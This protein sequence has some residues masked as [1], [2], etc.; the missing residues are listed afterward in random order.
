MPATKIE[1]DHREK[2]L[3]RIIDLWHGQK[4]LRVC[5]EAIPISLSHPRILHSNP[6]TYFVILSNILLGSRI[7]VGST[8]R[9]RSAPGLSC[10]MICDNTVS[11]SVLSC[12]RV[13]QIAREAAHHCPALA[14]QLWFRPPAH[15]IWTHPPTICCLY[16]RMPSVLCVR[17]LMCQQRC[18]KKRKKERLLAISWGRKGHTCRR[19][20]A[21]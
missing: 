10:E 1:F 11:I 13:L 20:P 7:N 16:S 5:H 6:S 8:T 14:P 21:M 12:A 9:L 19:C 3:S 15:R 17:C 18:Q 2:S 4:G